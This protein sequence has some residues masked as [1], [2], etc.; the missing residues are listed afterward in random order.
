[1]D[2]YSTN[3]DGL[4]GLFPFKASMVDPRMTDLGRTTGFSVNDF[5]RST[6]HASVGRM[7][8]MDGDGDG[9][10]RVVFENFGDVDQ[11]QGTDRRADLLSGLRSRR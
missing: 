2:N 6:S 5:S 4:R 1:M 11:G 9:A 10:G 8:E 7:G 3:D